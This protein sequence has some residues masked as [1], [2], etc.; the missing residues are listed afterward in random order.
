M[1][2]GREG[3]IIRVESVPF[4]ESWGMMEGLYTLSR[5][6]AQIDIM[7]DSLADDLT[8]PCVDSVVI[9]L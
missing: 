1:N 2:D 3:M 5:P 9:A 6:L 7:I 8:V 4:W